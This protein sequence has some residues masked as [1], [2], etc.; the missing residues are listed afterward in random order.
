M[1]WEPFLS[2]L[3]TVIRGQDYNQVCDM[4]QVFAETM[5]SMDQLMVAKLPEICSRVI[6]MVNTLVK[7]LEEGY[8]MEEMDEEEQDKL[9]DDTAEVEEVIFY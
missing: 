9:A 4:I 3:A 5:P 1:L 7:S 8:N 6:A 2:E